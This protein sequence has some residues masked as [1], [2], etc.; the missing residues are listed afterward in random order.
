MS[1]RRRRVV[2]T[3]KTQ[4]ENGL[5]FAAAIN[6]FI[7]FAE[8]RYQIYERRSPLFVPL[9][10]FDL[11]AGRANKMVLLVCVVGHCR[12]QPSLSVLDRTRATRTGRPLGKQ[13]FPV[14]QC[15]FI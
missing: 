5:F 6:P 10:P 12:L 4:E 13:S 1:G 2:K 8:R 14:N 7:S 11:A 15:Q 3:T 9:G